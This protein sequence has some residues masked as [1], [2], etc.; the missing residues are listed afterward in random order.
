MNTKGSTE[1]V[2]LLEADKLDIALVQGEV[3]H[4]VFVRH[5]AGAREPQGPD[6]DVSDAG[7]FV[8]RADSPYRAIADLKGKPIAW[9]A[10]GSGLMMLGRYAMDGLGLDADKDFQPVYL[11]NAG[12]GRRWCSTAG[13]RRSGAAASAGRASR[14]CEKRGRA[15]VS[16]R[17]TPSEIKRILAKHSFLKPSRSRPAAFPARTTDPVG[18]LVE[19]RAARPGPTMPWRVTSSRRFTSWSGWGGAPQ[20][21]V[22][23][24][25]K[26]TV[27]A[28]P[29]RAVSIPGLH[30][31]SRKPAFYVRNLAQP[32][33]VSWAAQAK[34]RCMDDKSKKDGHIEGEGSYSGTKA[35]N[36]AHRQVPEEGQG[37]RGRA[38][39]QDARSIPRRSAELTAAE[40][41]GHSGDPK[42]WEKNPEP[43]EID[44]KF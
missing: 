39:G 23:T 36:E 14:R 26:N 3:V 29:S 7:M 5:R 28:A 40:A 33:H 27:A 6:R 38:G 31:I 11:E 35:Y 2:A 20:Q 32:A 13:S 9:G 15:H 21:L 19:F 24:T 22:D 30:G 16:S 17:P 41:K 37:R 43:S 8:V 12:D 18:R 34:E 25:A 42:I 4:E 44:H 1:N 10:E